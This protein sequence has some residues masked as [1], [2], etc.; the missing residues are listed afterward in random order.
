MGKNWECVGECS[1]IFWFC[2][3]TALICEEQTHN[4]KCSCLDLWTDTQC[5][6]EFSWPTR[7]RLMERGTLWMDFLDPQGTGS[8]SEGLY[9]WIS[10]THK[11]QTCGAMDLTDE[12]YLVTALTREDLTHG[13]KT[14]LDW[15]FFSW[16]P[17]P[18]MNWLIVRR[19][20]W[21]NLQMFV[22]AEKSVG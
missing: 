18:M 4:A 22:W 3:K 7:N 9:E 15:E 13:A 20:E 19:L 11:E 17:W 14:Y 1:P 16:L 2:G 5:E 12:D 6:D 8:W 21:M 10:L